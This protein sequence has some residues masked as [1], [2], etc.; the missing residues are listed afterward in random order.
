[1]IRANWCRT[2]GGGAN[3]GDQLTPA[4][5][6]HFG[7]DVRWAPPHRASFVG[8]GSILS[9]VPSGWAGTILGT[10]F[11]RKGMR[12]EFPL[13]RVLAVRGR[14]T[15]DACKLP[16]STPLG[17][18]GIL[19]PDLFPGRPEKRSEAIV[20][21]HYVD[22]DLAARH[23]GLPV[24]SVRMKPAL[25]AAAIASAELVYTSSLHVLIAADAFGVPTILEPHGRVVGGS[26]KF[27]DYA[28]AM[29]SRIVM[30]RPYLSPRDA[31]AERQAELRGLF[32]MLAA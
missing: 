14:L 21:P 27:M 11:I 1:M 24:L 9:K 3:F 29:D 2:C 6:R 15:R 32:G 7:Y 17:D 16:R 13:A 22:T 4:L 5:L 25:L 28:S 8:V 18:P 26:F 20:V 23:P 19:I 12:R 10:G 30:G 31:M